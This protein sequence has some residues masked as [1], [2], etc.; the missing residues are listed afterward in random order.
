MEQSSLQYLGAGIAM[1]GALG[2]GLGLG[3][4]F[5]AWLGGISRNPA[6]A[7][8]MTLP[9]FIG[10]AATELVALL[11]FVIAFLLMNAGK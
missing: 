6:A 9:G 1:I 5:S 3:N 10:F 2:A 7:A 4:V 8:K 11:C